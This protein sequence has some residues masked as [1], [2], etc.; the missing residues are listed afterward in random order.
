MPPERPLLTIAIPTYN[1][2][3]YLS[4]LLES[5]LEQLAAHPEVELLS[6]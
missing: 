5:S 4:E 6:L 3:S 2:A 1:R